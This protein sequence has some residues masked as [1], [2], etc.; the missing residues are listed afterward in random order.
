MNHPDP[1]ADLERR[2]AALERA[3]A[4]SQAPPSELAPWSTRLRQS[5][6]DLARDQQDLQ[7]QVQ[8]LAAGF[9][10]WRA[11]QPVPP[12]ALQIQARP[13]PAPSPAWQRLAGKALRLPAAIWRR[14]RAASQGGDWLLA[15]PDPA[16]RLPPFAPEDVVLRSL[17][18]GELLLPN[19]LV[20][21]AQLAMALEDLYFVHVVGAAGEPEMV[22]V[23]RDLGAGDP[24]DPFKP[25]ADDLPHRDTP[26]GRTVE[27]TSASPRAVPRC[28]R[29]LRRLGDHWLR[30]TGGI[31]YALAAGP[32]APRPQAGPS[33]A[34]VLSGPLEGG[35]ELLLGE[36]VSAA[37]ARG[38]ATLA[39]GLTDD[40][41]Y[42][43]PLRT[44][45]AA[46]TPALPLPPFFAPEMRGLALA[47]LL[48]RE[49]VTTLCHVGPG[50]GFFDQPEILEL[51][52]GLHVVDLPLPSGQGTV[53]PLPRP[54]GLVQRTL[55]LGFGFAD[56]GLKTGLDGEPAPAAAT[57]NETALVLRPLPW[58]L[59]DGRG[60]ATRAATRRRLGLPEDGRIWLWLDDLV[61]SARP[62]DVVELARRRPQDLFWMVGR[63]PLEARV[64]D[65]LRFFGTAN[66]RRAAVVDPLDALT[67][68]DA[69]ISTSQRQIWPRVLL[70]ALAIGVPVVAAPDARLGGPSFHAATSLEA[71]SRILD[72][73][74][75]AAAEPPMPLA[76]ATELEAAE[77]AWLA[78]ALDRP[79]A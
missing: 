76:P 9:A 15:C 51:L 43:R 11:G 61:A 49:A 28:M 68:A 70:S 10:A 35:L 16:L 25:L 64:D 79:G 4:R 41:L 66:V 27:L 60:P 1:S 58:R 59:A 38:L 78:A 50:H 36:L 7:D 75:N 54:A 56:L 18:R 21:L 62:E 73:L 63:G 74:G 6:D 22:I 8:A 14:L 57:E 32:A 24:F 69:L 3:L 19:G 65:L 46:E 34:I 48:R 29:G 39:I 31:R 67:A 52:P 71:M 26:L 45:A 53:A 77:P 44:L 13:Q 23:R 33:L 17:G 2:L 55:T 40:R 12:S 47:Q 20:E 37:R 42:G 30:G 72:D 5:V